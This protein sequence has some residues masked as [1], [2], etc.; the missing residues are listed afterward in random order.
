MK[1]IPKEPTQ[2][3]RR[4]M[5]IVLGVNAIVWSVILWLAIAHPHEIRAWCDAAAPEFEKYGLRLYRCF[6]FWSPFGKYKI[7]E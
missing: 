4:V 5:V 6:E 1:V 7:G 3:S 2:T